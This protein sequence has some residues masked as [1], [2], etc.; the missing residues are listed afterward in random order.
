MG[1]TLNKGLK[2]FLKDTT[3]NDILVTKTLSNYDD[4]V[5]EEVLDYE[6]EDE[7]EPPLEIPIPNPYNYGD[8][9]RYEPIR[10]NNFTVIF[11]VETGLLDFM[12]KGVS[13][14]AWNRDY[15]WSS[16]DVIFFGL[17][18]PSTS[19]ILFHNVRELT[20]F[21]VIIM[22][23]DP[24]GVPIQKWTILVEHVEYMDFGGENNRET[25]SLQRLYM[26]LKPINCILNF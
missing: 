21:E 11:P 18:G 20:N 9:I 2:L 12:V 1:L 10:N 6:L 16:I 19:Q 8:I 14:P 13:S 4:D 3:K 24:T 26:R 15:G 25:T 5:F 17:M 7:Y 22:W 23:N